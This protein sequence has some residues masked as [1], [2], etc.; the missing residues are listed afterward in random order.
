MFGCLW[1]SFPVALKASTLQHCNVQQLLLLLLLE[2]R[3]LLLLGLLLLVLLGMLL[4]VAA[5]KQ[6]VFK[7]LIPWR[8]PPCVCRGRRI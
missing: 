1:R 6:R 5:V 7:C 3:L 2:L 4:G 8:A